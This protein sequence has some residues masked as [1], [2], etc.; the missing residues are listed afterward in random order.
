MPFSFAGFFGQYVAS[1]RLFASDSPTSGLF[2]PFLGAT[3]GFHF[4][5]NWYLIVIILFAVQKA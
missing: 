3:I 5:H 2:K 4:W 1:K